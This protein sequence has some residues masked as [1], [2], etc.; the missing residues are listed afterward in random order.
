MRGRGHICYGVVTAHNLGLGGGYV[1]G[2]G[3][4]DNPMK[5]WLHFDCSLFFRVHPDLSSEC[6]WY[7]S[8][9]VY[10]CPRFYGLGY[11]LLRA[12]CA[13]SLLLCHGRQDVEIL[14]NVAHKDV[15]AS[16]YP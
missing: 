9:V 3:A 13:P 1:V 14:L 15:F 12:L 16:S 2:D 4:W 5:S 11:L 8:F 10:H 6:L 7:I